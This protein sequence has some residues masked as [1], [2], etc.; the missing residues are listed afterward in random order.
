MAKKSSE[1]P[2]E[3]L[4]EQGKTAYFRRE[5]KTAFELFEKAAE[6]NDAEALCRLGEFYDDFGHGFP[7][8]F[9]NARALYEKSYALGFARA[10]TQLSTL[11]EDNLA[12]MR[13]KKKADELLDEA[14]NRDDPLAKVIKALKTDDEEEGLR[15][16]LEAE[17]DEAFV[18]EFGKF[19]ALVKFTAKTDLTPKEYDKE[20]KKLVKN[21]QSQA[22][23]VVN[24]SAFNLLCAVVLSGQD[25]DAA[26]MFFR[27]SAENGPSR[28]KAECAYFLWSHGKKGA[29][30]L[31]LE[32]VEQS[33]STKGMLALGACYLDGSEMPQ[34]AEDAEFW[35]K[36]ALT[37][38]DPEV[39]AKVI[40][41]AEYWLGRLELD[42]RDNPEAAQNYFRQSAE[43]GNTGAGI[44]LC[45]ILFS[46]DNP[47][48]FEWAQKLA[49]DNVWQGV[50]VLAS[51]YR[52]GLGVKKDYQKFVEYVRKL[53]EN[54]IADGTY[55]LATAY[56]NGL[57]IPENKD[58]AI[59]LFKRA[60]KLGDKD[61]AT[62]IADIYFH[63]NPPAPQTFKWAKKGVENESD[64]A[65]LILACC[66]RDGIGT[67]RDPE[68]ELRWNLESAAYG[69]AVG[70]F[71]AGLIY[72]SQDKYTQ[73]RDLLTSAYE[74]GCINAAAILS[75][76]EFEDEDGD[77]AAA[78]K[79][80]KIAIEKNDAGGYPVLGACYFHGTGGVKRN[81]ARAIELW[82]KGAALGDHHCRRLLE[83][84]KEEAPAPLAEQSEAPGK[85]A[86]SGSQDHV[87]C[88]HC[89]FKN[90]GFAKFCCACGKKIESEK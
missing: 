38:S 49:E 32:S 70:S 66:Y 86:D 59:R 43:H 11:L 89:G 12:G 14:C 50:S 10:G 74:K 35:L 68:E 13:D 9:K 26:E 33:R 46:Q 28:S 85:S 52:D 45:K 58:K 60:D 17:A 30:K 36:K 4:R 3:S 21:F 71:N 31:A 19:S 72:Y 40:A 20:L 51:C 54:D 16:F 48:A 87:F 18:R 2:A 82:R 53:D 57:G 42:L 63:Q 88:V 76:C 6:L 79:W 75:K 44:M 23:N 78:L 25:D 41:L 24:D 34:K 83:D 64:G 29:G 15:L 84:E 67:E 65:M 69:N 5:F 56:Q 80:A 77:K 39:E 27:K 81:R 73:A 47:E 22:K 8:D 62:Q 37:E 61:A 1:N 90:P 55:M 7:V